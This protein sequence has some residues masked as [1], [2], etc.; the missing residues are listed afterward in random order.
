MRATVLID[1]L[2]TE[3]FICEWGLAI[4][5]EY[6]GKNYLLDSG[7]TDGFARNAQNMGVDLSRVHAGVLSHAHADHSDGIP[8]F[9]AINNHAKFHMRKNTAPN[10]YD[11]NVFKHNRYI[12]IQKDLLTT[13]QDRIVMVSGDYKLDEGV[14]LI[15]HKTPGLEAMGKR[16]G[17]YMRKHHKWVLDNYEHEQSLVFETEKGLVIFNSC[18]HAG[19]AAIIRE[20]ELTFPHKPIHAIIG[21]FHLYRSSED[22]IRTLARSMLETGIELAVTG[23]CTTDHGYDVLRG[24]M[25]DKVR[26]MYTGMIIEI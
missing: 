1:N 4:H 10:C 24:E 20:I 6:N 13:Y 17:M 16:N 2:P 8:A 22:F 15:P 23:H 18:S 11:R 12:G 19:A 25:G 7:A 26:Q 3:G 5:I 9:F 14:W 21:G